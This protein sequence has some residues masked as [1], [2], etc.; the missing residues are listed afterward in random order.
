MAAPPKPGYKA[1]IFSGNVNSFS[2]I[3]DFVSS[4]SKSGQILSENSLYDVDYYIDSGNFMLN[5]ILSGSVLG[6][7]SGGRIHTISGD[8][9][10]G[11]SYVIY[12]AIK[13]FQRDNPDG[14][15]WFWET[16]GSGT[17][18]RMKGQGIDITRVRIE[19]P[20]TVHEVSIPI[21][22]MTENLEAS[23][24]KNQKVPK[25]LYVVDSLNGLLSSKALQDVLDGAVKQDMGHQAKELKLLFNFCSKRLL[26]TNST[27]LCTA[28]VY[29]NK[30][31][32][33]PIISGGMGSVYFSS[34]ITHLRKKIERDETT[35]EATGVVVTAT[36]LECRHCMPHQKTEMK[37]NFNKGMNPYIGLHGYATVES[38][39]VGKGRMMDYC[40]LLNEAVVKKV[41]NVDDIKEGLVDLDKLEA[42]ISKDKKEVLDQIIIGNIR[43]GQCVMIGSDEYVKGSGQKLAFSD[44]A[45]SRI[46]DGKVTSKGLPEK[47]AIGNPSSSVWV[48]DKLQKSIDNKTF[49]SAEVFTLDVL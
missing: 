16:E 12:S 5:A 38:C 31:T 35:R 41:F 7:F 11:K 24:A 9:K 32:G 23:I 43:N 2:E 29:E 6:G 13:N 45:I 25:I 4:F 27:L 48:S 28:H 18:D 22:R 34:T 37:I 33:Q 17:K 44:S 20:M 21:M 49:F 8:P 10:T 40:D 30:E 47:Q 39:G 42:V 26:K 46:I 15:V 36:T 1:K 3:N 19:T 14:F